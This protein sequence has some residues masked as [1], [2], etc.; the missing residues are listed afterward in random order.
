MVKGFVE[1]SR[2]P[3]EEWG[4]LPGTEP[5]DEF[6]ELCAVSTSG[7]LTE[8]ENRRLQEHLAVCPECRSALTQYQTIID[9]AIPAIRAS[10]VLGRDEE[11]EWLDQKVDPGPGWSQKRAERAL[12]D[13]L[14]REPKLSEPRSRRESDNVAGSTKLSGIS[15]RLNFPAS[16]ASEASSPASE[17][18]ESTWRQ[19]WMLY[20]AGILLFAALSLFAYR[21]GLQQRGDGAGV[22]EP[23]RSTLDPSLLQAQLSD[24]GHE[25]EVLRAQMAQRDGWIAD[26]RRQLSRQSEESR[27]ARADQ[28]RLEKDLRTGEAAR[29]ALLQ[30]RSE[31]ARKFDSADT[32]SRALQE[33]LDA[34]ARQSAQDAAGAKA[35]EA[36]VNE[37]TRLLNQREAALEQQEQLLSHDRDIRDLM[38]A[39]DLYIAEV[40]D[41]AGSGETKKPY[42]RVF[43]T[44]GKSL[45]FYAYDLDQQAARK[46][47][48]T[49]QAWG[50]RGPDRQMAL[51]LGVFYQDNDSQKR[52]ILKCDDPKTLAQIDAVFVT[53][54]PGAGSHKPSSKSLL[55]AYLKVN[56]N[57]P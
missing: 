50:R 40:Y 36:K 55:F 28:A 52:W 19:M 8:E 11:A 35:G 23:P 27:E 53:V 41:I 17:L 12:F 29:Q 26:L 30:Q 16:S 47:A 13:R 31:L 3:S 46:K 4:R 45:I 51:N 43:Y 44:R 42:G 10:A 22:I 5:H 32:S 57:H 33:K 14:G 56:P 1:S 39:R 48:N 6:L 2:V 54:E 9:Q 20:A 38:G 37:L 24:A 7:E 18:N 49:F 15:R 34:L 21:V 25:Q